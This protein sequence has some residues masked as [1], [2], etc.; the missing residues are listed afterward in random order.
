M[1]LFNNYINIRNFFKKKKI[2][3]RLGRGPGSGKG[4]TCGRGHK[5]QKS[6]AGYSEKRGFEGGQTPLYRRLPKF[7]FV[8]KK[9]KFL[10]TLRLDDIYRTK[11]KYINLKV[12]KNI[13]MINKKVVDVKI[14]GPRSNFFKNEIIVDS[15]FVSKKVKFYIEC[16]GGCILP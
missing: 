15:L 1:L 5:G 7:G 16:F 8:S 4:K 13:R 9:N 3:K 14:L 11:Q 2:S 6:R 12:L 10:K